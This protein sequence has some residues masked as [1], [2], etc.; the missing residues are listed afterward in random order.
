MIIA[1]D[2]AI[3][4]GDRF[5]FRCFPSSVLE[6]PWF[7]KL[8]GAISTKAPRWGIAK[9]RDWLRSRQVLIDRSVRKSLKA[10][11]RNVG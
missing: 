2:V 5:E 7:I 11:R 6:R 10:Q 9:W 3:A 8:E 1:G 4:P